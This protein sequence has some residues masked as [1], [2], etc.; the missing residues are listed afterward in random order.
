M[1]HP[2]LLVYETDGLLAGLLR[3]LARAKVNRWALREPRQAEAC[4]R[5][6]RRGGPSVVV[7][8]VGRDLLREFTLLERAY[9][10][11]PEAP[12]IVV[13]DVD[14]VA[15][16]NLAW[17]LGATYV[18]FSPEAR[19]QLPGLVTSLFKTATAAQPPTLE[20]DAEVGDVTLGTSDDDLPKGEDA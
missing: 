5:L 8:K 11:F 16:T 15:L 13:G 4:L 20:R 14:D 9:W 7:L 19:T 3:P 10:L 2:Q 1:R 6:L 18:L 12:R 17:D